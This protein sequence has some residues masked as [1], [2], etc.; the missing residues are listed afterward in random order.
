MQIE[1]ITKSTEIVNGDKLYLLDIEKLDNIEKGQV[2]N[3]V[4]LGADE[5]FETFL[6]MKEFVK[7][8]EGF[9]LA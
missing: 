3:G 8:H 9:S 4:R 2:I 7:H 1:E 6:R 5:T